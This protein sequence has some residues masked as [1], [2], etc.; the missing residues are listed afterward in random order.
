M[1]NVPNKKILDQEAGEL[2]QVLLHPLERQLAGKQKIHISP[3]GSLNLIPFEVLKNA[4]GA[5]QIES[6]QISY[7]AAGRDIM[8]F[9]DKESHN[10]SGVAALILADPDFDFG[11]EVKEKAETASEGEPE[12]SSRAKALNFFSRL[13]ETSYEADAIQKILTQRMHIPAKNYQ[14]DKAVGHVD[15]GASSI[16]LIFEVLSRAAR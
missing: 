10:K 11:L 8:R 5:Y 12:T 14:K 13:P 4:Q 6:T 15:A 7:I 1:G 3:D 16:S 9:D 2:F